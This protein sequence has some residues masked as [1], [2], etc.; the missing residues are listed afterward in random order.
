MPK[1]RT[2]K[3]KNFELSLNTLRIC[4]QALAAVPASNA[5]Q[6]KVLATALAEIELAIGAVPVPAES[7]P[8]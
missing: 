4:H 7:Q 6:A 8:E 3:I 2:P 1:A 5:Q